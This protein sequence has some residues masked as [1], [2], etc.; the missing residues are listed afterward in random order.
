MTTLIRLFLGD[1]GTSEGSN[2]A[3]MPFGMAKTSSGA[4]L[5]L[6]KIYRFFDSLEMFLDKPDHRIGRRA[7]T[8][9]NDERQLIA[10][11]SLEQFIGDNRT[12]I[13]EAF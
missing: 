3:E 5:D 8:D 2:E 7:I 13:G 9:T 1:S 6:Q 12:C 11:S 4:I 10:Q